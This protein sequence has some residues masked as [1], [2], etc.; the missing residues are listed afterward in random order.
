MEVQAVQ[1]PSAE[2]LAEFGSGKL[3]DVQAAAVVT[4]LENCPQCCQKAATLS[5]DS[6]LVRLRAVQTSSGTAAPNKTLADPFKTRAD[7]EAFKGTNPPV[8]AELRDHPHYQIVRELG[9]GGMGVV[10]LA[11]NKLMDRLE[12]LKVVNRELLGDPGA[13]ER[14]LREIRSAAKLS[15]ANIVTAY[16]Q[17][18]RSASF[19]CL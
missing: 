12:V 5:G 13:K 6:F 17:R 4:H 19:W 3:D 1:H 10:Y 15:Q 8:P 7:S 2:T 9:R 11:K 18:S 14:F 16:I